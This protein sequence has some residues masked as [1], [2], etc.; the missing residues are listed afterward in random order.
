[1]KKI[2]FL[3]FFGLVSSFSNIAL[4][5]TGFIP[6]QIW[7]ST[8]SFKEG[9]VVKIYTVVWNGESDTLDAKVDFFNDKILLGTRDISVSPGATK[10]VS[11]SWRVTSGNNTIF[12]KITSSYL[13]QNREIL[14]LKNKETDKDTFFVPMVIITESGE[15]VSSGKIIENQINKT[16]AKILES[17]PE[18]VS[19]PTYSFFEKV[20]SFREGNL[21][22]IEENKDNSKEI[23]ESYK[24]LDSEKK[25]EDNKTKEI[26][27]SS[28]E[29]ENDSDNNDF[30]V[31]RPLEY[32]KFF[33][34]SVFA[35]IFKYKIIFYGIILLIVFGLIKFIYRKIRNL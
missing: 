3:L 21:V 9:D 26:D 28:K 31:K 8:E 22:K 1:M 13:G 5:S 20:D 29:K 12:A 6:G 14:S 25:E 15:E 24:I 11:I 32:I 4:A 23:I 7:Y 35:L 17:I 27:V 16:T 30:E 33:F 10:Q 19:E 34:L 2:L 18:S